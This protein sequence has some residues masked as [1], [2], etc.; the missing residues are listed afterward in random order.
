M[1]DCSKGTEVKTTHQD[2]NSGS[3][4]RIEQDSRRK[5][6]E[7]LPSLVWGPRASSDSYVP[8]RDK[9]E[10]NELRLKKKK[11]VIERNGMEKTNE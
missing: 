5:F 8:T 3:E 11:K 6:K 9:L 1:V 4:S 10:K 2:P 7:I